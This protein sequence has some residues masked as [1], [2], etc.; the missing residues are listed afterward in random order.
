MKK[1]QEKKK[2][3]EEGNSIKDSILKIASEFKNAVEER[4]LKGL[5]AVLGSG[6][7]WLVNKPVTAIE[8]HEHLDQMTEGSK[9]LTFNLVKVRDFQLKGDSACLDA[10]CQLIWTNDESWEEMEVCF[11]LHIGFYKTKN[12]WAIKYLGII[13]IPC[14]SVKLDL[15]EKPLE[16]YFTN[17]AM[18]THPG[19]FA[20]TEHL[21]YFS[22][23][24]TLSYFDR[25]S[26][27]TEEPKVE[28]KEER[29]S[30]NMIPVYMPVLIPG[31]YIKDFIKGK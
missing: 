7:I 26:G 1:K 31:H 18:A 22:Y 11:L 13:V 30:S 24:E 3:V 28:K 9:D 25:G 10:E 6:S 4:S 8:L 23:H 15:G 19:Y 20:A 17:E 29:P 14:P 2:D 12:G 21:P 5:K 16:N 27:A